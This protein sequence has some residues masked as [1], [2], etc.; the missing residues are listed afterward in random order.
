MSNTSYKIT[1]AL[2]STNCS[3]CHKPIL[4]GCCIVKLDTGLITH[5]LCPDTSSNSPTNEKDP[6][7]TADSATLPCYPE[8]QV[9]LL[10]EDIARW[11]EIITDKLR[12]H[13][14]DM[15]QSLA[16]E[17][18][19][20]IQHATICALQLTV[21][22]TSS[23]AS[24]LPTTRS[25]NTSITPSE[26]ETTPRD[27]IVIFLKE[28][29]DSYK[30]SHR[31]LGAA[32]PGLRAMYYTQTIALQKDTISQLE[33]QNTDLATPHQALASSGNIARPDQ[34]TTP[35]PNC[36][37]ARLEQPI[38]VLTNT[39]ALATDDTTPPDL[40]GA[41][42]AKEN[43]IIQTLRDDLADL[44]QSLSD[45]DNTIAQLQFSLDRAESSSQHKSSIITL[46]ESTIAAHKTTITA[47]EST[48]TTL[49]GTVKL[50]KDTITTLSRP[51]SPR[52]FIIWSKP[53]SMILAAFVLALFL[54]APFYLGRLR[55][56]KYR[57]SH[58]TPPSSS[59]PL[60]AEGLEELRVNPSP[61]AHDIHPY[62]TPK[63]Q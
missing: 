51:A 19:V 26:P 36:R 5:A 42:T 20:A 61:A 3:A 27:S 12:W 18:I 53:G 37:I 38:P 22:P 4:K 11:R 49:H 33:A 31:I 6:T 44:E 45:R 1:I 13:A 52:P 63:L 21:A 58:L 2:S 30:E 10:I 43:E 54:L 41:P 14:E 57:S 17:R 48:I 46:Q 56:N 39:E 8:A 59:A 47:Q 23:L 28:L 35:P 34:T 7:S 50:L 60:S 55:E 40:P 25:A 29:L 9:A 62:R 32:S 15:P 16:N 24:L